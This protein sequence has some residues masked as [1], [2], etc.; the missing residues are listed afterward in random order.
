MSLAR[1]Q[2]LEAF[3]SLLNIKLDERTDV[4]IEYSY[5]GFY[6]TGCYDLR[7]E[8]DRTSE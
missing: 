5:V 4:K 1:K 8:V 3:F 7:K 2:N 6:D